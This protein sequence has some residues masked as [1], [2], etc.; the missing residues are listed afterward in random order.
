ME[1]R[2]SKKHSNV[3]D[4]HKNFKCLLYTLF[5]EFIIIIRGKKNC[6]LFVPPKCIQQRSITILTL[7]VPAKFLHVFI[8]S[9]FSV[10]CN[11]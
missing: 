9:W 1:K 8:G 10:L 3:F 5:I 6:I 2:I 7:E 11:L 4:D